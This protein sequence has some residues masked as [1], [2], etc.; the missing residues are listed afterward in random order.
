MKLRSGDTMINRPTKLKLNSRELVNTCFGHLLIGCRNKLT[1]FH[2]L[3]LG[4]KKI[5]RMKVG[6]VVVYSSSHR[7]SAVRANSDA[8]YIQRQLSLTLN[9]IRKNFRNNGGLGNYAFVVLEPVRITGCDRRH[10]NH[11]YRRR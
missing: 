8:G 11:N 7:P 10:R 2:L 4:V 6:E 3:L 5:I 9:T 1:R